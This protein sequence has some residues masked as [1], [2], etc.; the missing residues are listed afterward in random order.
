MCFIKHLLCVFTASM[1][2]VDSASAQSIQQLHQKAIET[3]QASAWNA[4]AEKLYLERKNPELLDTAT[5]NAIRL[6]QANND[7]I[8]WGEALIYASDLLYQ[9]GEFHLY[10]KPIVMHLIC[11]VTLMLMA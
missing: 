2:W 11:F 10:Q 4:L 6:A 3:N 9:K 8:Q 7:T 5:Q 1:L